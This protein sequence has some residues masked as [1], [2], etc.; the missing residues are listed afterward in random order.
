[1][2]ASLLSHFYK[3]GGPNGPGAMHLVAVNISIDNVSATWPRGAASSRNRLFIFC[4]FEKVTVV[5]S[6]LESL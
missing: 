5:V 2:D 1:L 3:H 6:N 4:W